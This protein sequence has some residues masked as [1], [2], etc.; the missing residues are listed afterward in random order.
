VLH[1]VARRTLTDL[2]RPGLNVACY[3]HATILVSLRPRLRGELNTVDTVRIRS[4]YRT[5]CYATT[6]PGNTY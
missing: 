6:V 1:D 4:H 3:T 2:V 5:V